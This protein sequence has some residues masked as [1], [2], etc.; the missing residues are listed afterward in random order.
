MTLRGRAHR[1]PVLPV[2]GTE[3]ALA[4]QAPAALLDLVARQGE[5]PSVAGDP[6]QLHEGHLD[7]RMPIDAIA[8]GRAD[9][10][11]DTCH[12]ALGDLEQSV[13]AERALPCDGRLD[14]VADAIQLVAPLQVA[15]GR[16]ARQL[17]E[18]AQVAVRALRSRHE[19]DGL[20][21]HLPQ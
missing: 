19:P 18:R 13:V 7:L 16:P 2:A 6:V 21:R 14:E 12:G 5:V 9:L 1:L 11:V 15:E 20:V 10:G 3:P 8:T 17:H 4:Q